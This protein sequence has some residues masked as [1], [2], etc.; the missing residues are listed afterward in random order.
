MVRVLADNDDLDLVK[1]TQ[2]KR[3]E[4]EA[5]RRIDRAMGILLLYK[6]CQGLEVGL[7]KLWLEM[8]LPTL[9]YLYF[10]NVGFGVGV[11]FGF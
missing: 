9:V 5:S 4:Y 7:V 6:V 11:G 1:R 2:V 8:L 3:V 10:H